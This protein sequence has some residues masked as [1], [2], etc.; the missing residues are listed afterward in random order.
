MIDFNK[1]KI[2]QELILGKKYIYELSL[3]K[4]KNVYRIYAL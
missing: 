3:R 4:K 1:I 2:E